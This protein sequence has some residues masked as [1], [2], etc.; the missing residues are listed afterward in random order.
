MKNMRKPYN[1]RNQEAIMHCQA[2]GVKYMQK[3][4]QKTKYC[5]DPCKPRDSTALQNPSKYKTVVF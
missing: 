2:W 5:T 1:L 4:S 3:A